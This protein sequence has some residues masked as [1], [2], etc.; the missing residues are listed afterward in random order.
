MTVFLSCAIVCMASCMFAIIED[1]G[2]GAAIWF[3]VIY[4]VFMLFS[5]LA[6]GTYIKQIEALEKRLDAIEQTDTDEE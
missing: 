3:A 1:R 6:E 2:I 5:L 4:L